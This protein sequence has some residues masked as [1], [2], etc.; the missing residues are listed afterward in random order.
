[1]K[2]NPKFIQRDCVE[3]DKADL[4][5]AQAVL[6]HRPDIIIFEMS[7]SNGGPG[8]VFNRYSC[9]NKPFEKVN[10]IISKLKVSAKKYPYA[11]SDIAVWE[12][13]K[14]LW[15]DGVNAQIYNVDA[16]DRMRREF[17]LFTAEGYPSV[18]K[19]W[20][21]WTYLYLRDTCMA[22]NIKKA[23]DGY[24]KKKNPTVLIFLQSI[25]WKHAQFLLTDPSKEKIWEF[26]F[27]RFPRVKINMIEK[28]IRERSKVLGEYWKKNSSF[29]KHR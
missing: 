1:M 8:I 14:A 4:R 15:E 24:S 17:N 16:P 10:E 12:N 18:R 7:C 23:L 25:H 9:E 21:F 22:R 13:I 28:H 29:A 2:L 6:K 11:E 27:G 5:Q 19:D 26:Y 3:G 20:L